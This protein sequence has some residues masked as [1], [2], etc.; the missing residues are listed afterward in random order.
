MLGK[1][2]KEKRKELGLTQQALSDK[3]RI[4]KSYVAMI[5]G[6]NAI[7]NKKILDL[8]STIIGDRDTLY[9]LAGKIPDDVICKIKNS[10]EKWERIRDGKI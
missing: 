5:E 8:F 7:P 3:M 2:I 4:S 1:F 9:L 6:G 10:P